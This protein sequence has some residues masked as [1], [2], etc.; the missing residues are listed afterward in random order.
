[1]LTIKDTY[2]NDSTSP[3]MD[4]SRLESSSVVQ[5]QPK[6]CLDPDRTNSQFFWTWTE[7]TWTALD[8]Y[9]RAELVRIHWELLI[10]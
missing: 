4:Q 3:A 5:V 1:M 6:K 2:S 10:H 8:Q 7:L 9:T